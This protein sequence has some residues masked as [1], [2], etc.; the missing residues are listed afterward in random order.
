MRNRERSLQGKMAELFFLCFLVSVIPTIAQSPSDSPP[1]LPCGTAGV[2][3]NVP[4][5]EAKT[6]KVV[7][8]NTPSQVPHQ[9]PPQIPAPATPEATSPTI[10]APVTT[11]HSPTVPPPSAQMTPQSSESNQPSV[12]TIQP[13]PE[14]TETGQGTYLAGQELGQAIGARIYDM[15]VRHVINNACF[16]KHAEAW[17]LP[18]GT[19]IPCADWMKANPKEVKGRPSLDPDSAA[20]EAISALCTTHPHAWYTIGT[21]YNYSCKDWK[22]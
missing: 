18:D 9:P 4:C 19:I 3:A 10:P 15:R 1:L 6:G 8:T 14:S 16:V 21:G 7:N 17:K 11:L 20:G 22:K 12:P 13:N 2:P 5:L